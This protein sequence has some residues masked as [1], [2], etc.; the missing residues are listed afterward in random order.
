MAETGNGA[1]D[2]R[3][4]QLLDVIRGAAGE[5]ERLL[6]RKE[7]RWQSR[8]PWSDERERQELKRLDGGGRG[9]MTDKGCIYRERPQQC[10]MCGKIDELRP[11]GPSGECVCFECGMKDKTAAVRQ[12]KHLQGRDGLTEIIRRLDGEGGA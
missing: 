6:E 8:E 3:I 11:Y 1:R 12:F 4:Q 9:V 5:I 2:L 7:T 10:D